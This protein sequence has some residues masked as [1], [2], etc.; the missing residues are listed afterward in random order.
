MVCTLFS[1]HGVLR[2]C[3]DSS[4]GV[5]RSVWNLDDFGGVFGGSWVW[6]FF[7]VFF[8]LDRFDCLVHVV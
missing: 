7:L 5:V 4:F 3:G 1:E 8:G 2:F 6:F